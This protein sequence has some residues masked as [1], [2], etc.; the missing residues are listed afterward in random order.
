MSKLFI[1]RF[2]DVSKLRG[3]Q[4]RQRA[5]VHTTAIEKCDALSTSASVLLTVQRYKCSDME[6]KEAIRHASTLDI[7]KS[8]VLFIRQFQ[9]QKVSFLQ[10][11]DQRKFAET[12]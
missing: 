4:L 6:E 5:S 11:T 2:G 1:E 12:I 10:C 9:I 7:S 8:I 3:D